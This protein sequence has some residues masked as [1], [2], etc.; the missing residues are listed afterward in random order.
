M[1][2][3]TPSA[4]KKIKDAIAAEGKPSL[5]LRVYV[6][7]GGCSG[8][9]YGLTFEEGEQEGDTTVECDGFRI[10]IDPFSRPY[11]EGVNIDYKNTLQEAGFKFEN[12]TA[13]STCSCGQ[14]FKV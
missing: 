2:T 1:I 11:L 7:G 13:T 4:V 14:S 3:L 12:P 5:N 9:Q 8:L 10:M 6:E